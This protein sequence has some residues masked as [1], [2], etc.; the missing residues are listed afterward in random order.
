M[1]N[2]INLKEA[3]LEPIVYIEKNLGLK[4]LCKY[5]AIGG[6]IFLLFNGKT[7]VRDCIEM[8]TEIKNSIH[9]EKM[10]LRDE[11]LAELGP[12]LADFRS[13]VRADRILY[14]EYHNSKENLIGIPFKY[15]ELVRQN[16]S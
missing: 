16:Q 2:K 9:T 11:L 13:N 8:I 1:F 14:F 15:L 12:I 7:V 3:L 6:I 10:K 5:L 4:A